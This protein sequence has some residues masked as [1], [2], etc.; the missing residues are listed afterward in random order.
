MDELDN[1]DKDLDDNLSVC[2]YNGSD[3][4]NDDDQPCN[5]MTLMAKRNV[6]RFLGFDNDDNLTAKTSASTHFTEYSISSSVLPRNSN[7]KTLD[8]RFEKMY[9]HEYANDLDIGALNA[10]EINGDIDPNNSEILDQLVDDFQQFKSELAQGYKPNKSSIDYIRHYLKNDTSYENEETSSD[11]S[12]KETIRIVDTVRKGDKDRFDCES[13]LSTNTNTFYQPTIL[14]DFGERKIAKQKPINL[15]EKNLEKQTNSENVHNHDDLQS[16][17]S[18]TSR[19]TEL[20]VRP[21]KETTE[22]RR[23]RKKELKE[24][25]AQRRAEKKCNRLAFNTEKIRMQKVN[26]QKKVSVL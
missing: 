12:E 14:D 4:E 20:S 2:G 17:K 16:I 5:S 8:E 3:D 10:D 13:I 9:I 6:K 11:E 21:K 19:L 1:D 15:A 7:L 23:Q 18:N 22:E 26:S 24:Y 25:R